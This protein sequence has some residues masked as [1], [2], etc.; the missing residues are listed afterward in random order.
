MLGLGLYS[1]PVT[2]VVQVTWLVT[3]NGSTYDT[4]DKAIK[5]VTDS[6][7][8][9]QAAEEFNLP[10]STLGDQISGRT[11]HGA[12]SNKPQYLTDEEEDIL[13]KLLLS[14]ASIA[15]VYPHSMVQ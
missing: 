5:A 6:M 3:R 7:S 13:V 12:K 1:G 9:Q 10:K 2:M 4:M 15:I 11:M 14:C 8:I